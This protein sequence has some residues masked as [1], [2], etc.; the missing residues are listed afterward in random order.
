MRAA[1]EGAEGVLHLCPFTQTWFFPT[2]LFFWG[3]GLL[4]AGGEE[5]FGFAVIRKLEQ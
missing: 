5:Q 2:M 3:G 1:P 4:R